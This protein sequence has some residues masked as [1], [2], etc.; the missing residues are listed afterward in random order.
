[1]SNKIINNSST[2]TVITYF[3]LKKIMIQIQIMRDKFF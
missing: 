2:N 3:S 1:M